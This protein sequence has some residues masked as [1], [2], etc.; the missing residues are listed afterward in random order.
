MPNEPQRSPGF[1]QKQ[2]PEVF[3]KKKD[4]LKKFANFTG[5][6]LFLIKLLARLQHWCFTVKFAKFLEHLFGRTSA[7]DCFYRGEFGLDETL[8][9]CKVS[10]FLHITILFDHMQ[11]YHL[12]IS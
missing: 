8:T 6:H 5:K 10:I 9:E 4:V 1:V 11:P 2:P 7:K 3:G 12:Y